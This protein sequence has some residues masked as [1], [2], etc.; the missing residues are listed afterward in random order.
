[1]P[2]LAVVGLLVVLSFGVVDVGRYLAAS[3]RAATAADAAALAA[4]PVTF[5]PFGAR[6][7]PVAEAARLASANGTRLVWCACSVDPGFAT[8]E[9][10]VVVTARVDLVLFGSRRVRASSRAEFNPTAVL[11]NR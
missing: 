4:A 11:P 9:V 7:S 10:E 3:S 1:M 5:R 6:G 8:R 2:M